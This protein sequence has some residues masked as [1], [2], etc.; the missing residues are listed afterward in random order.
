[1]YE[2]PPRQLLSKPPRSDD[3]IND[4]RLPFVLAGIF[5]GCAL[6][7]P[8]RPP[9]S[10]LAFVGILCLPAMWKHVASDANLRRLV[11]LWG[12]SWVAI[13]LLHFDDLIPSLASAAFPLLIIAATGIF[14]AVLTSQP[15]HTKL[16]LTAALTGLAVSYLAWPSIAAEQIGLLKSGVGVAVAAL[17]ILHLCR[18][19]PTSVRTSVAITMCGAVVLVLDGR[20]LALI[21]VLTG[22]VTLSLR[23]V[24]RRRRIILSL[25]ITAAAAFSLYSAYSQLAS[26]GAFGENAR[27]RYVAQFEENS[28]P[29]SARPEMALS[30]V[31]I[32]HDPFIG[33]GG[34][35]GFSTSERLEAL[36]L[37]HS[38][39]VQSTPNG[40]RRLVGNGINSHSILLGTWVEV[41]VLG[42]IPWIALLVFLS[43]SVVQA[44]RRNYPFAPLLLFGV[45]SLGWDLL[46]SPWSRGYEIL[47]GIWIALAIVSGRWPNTTVRPKHEGADYSSPSWV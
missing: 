17:I 19:N 43:G 31:A 2:T 45:A 5:L 6:W 30:F 37:V 42:A 1:V 26:S 32:R 27:E 25:V 16:I 14:T 12:G 11:L 3:R 24:R 28:S 13:A 38:L 47:A 18:G 4:V 8:I 35:V 39:G 7:L 15:K 10:L 29:L 22:A 33:R 21:L 20:N 46:F 23:G 36:G 40:V 9:S 41:G 44:F 34:K